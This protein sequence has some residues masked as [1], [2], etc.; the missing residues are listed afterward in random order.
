[1]WYVEHCEKHQEEKQGKHALHSFLLHSLTLRIPSPTHSPYPP[2]P[3]KTKT[4]ERE[5]NHAV[6]IVGYGTDAKTGLDYLLIK[7]SWGTSWGERGF[8]RIARGMLQDGKRVDECGLGCIEYYVHAP[9]GGVAFV[10]GTAVEDDDYPKGETEGGWQGGVL[11][12]AY[13]V[14]AGMAVVLVGWL[15]VS[16]VHG[17]V[18]RWRRGGG[19]GGSGGMAEP[20]LRL[21]EEEDR[22]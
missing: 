17:G 10:N 13:D 2:P 6:A 4:T 5:L 9:V 12:L 3:F 21:E 19:G 1:M 16:L 11:E 15:I 18:K 7:N 22:G 8:A 20:L 14:A